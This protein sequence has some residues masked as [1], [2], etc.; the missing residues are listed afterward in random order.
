MNDIQ[1]LY[2]LLNI[3]QKLGS[4]DLRILYLKDVWGLDQQV[5]AELEGI[6]QSLVS[7]KIT[8]G[9]RQFTRPDIQNL[10]A[11]IDWTIE[12]LLFLQQL[13]REII[14]DIP[15]VSF[16]IYI[17]GIKLT[18]PFYFLYDND[19]VSMAALHSL[20]IQNKRIQELFKKTQ[21]TVSMAVKRNLDRALKIEKDTRY[22]FNITNIKL[23]KLQA[24]QI[25]NLNKF[26]I[27]SI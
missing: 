22:S 16:I 6:S 1:N 12:E 18:H 2:T 3:R 15:L 17:L 9:R 26:T 10:N 4:Q 7:R 24:K 19:N 21:P 13:P 27:A 25:T 11:S 14:K 8:E 20:G 23:E 5:I